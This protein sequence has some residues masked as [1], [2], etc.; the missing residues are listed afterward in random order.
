[1]LSKL[2]L[3]LTRYAQQGNYDVIV[4]IYDANDVEAVQYAPFWRKH[5]QTQLYD[6]VRE[7]WRAL[8]RGLKVL[9]REAT[10]DATLPVLLF[11]NK[12]DAQHPN[13]QDL[14]QAEV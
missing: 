8:K 6:F 7:V 5:R 14:Q 12:A 4:M 10:S 1:M 11:A 9:L 2:R 13:D 3:A